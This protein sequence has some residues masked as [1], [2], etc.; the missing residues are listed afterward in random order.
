MRRFKY[1]LIP[2]ITLIAL[3]PLVDSIYS[4]KCEEVLAQKDITDIKHEYNNILR[5]RGGVLKDQMVNDKD[6]LLLGSSELSSDVEQNP[7]N[8]FPFT[9]SEYDVSIF[10]R[11]YSQSLQHSSILNSMNNLN[12]DDKVALI[13]SLQWFQRPDGIKGEEY[14]VNFS[15]YQFYKMINSNVIS[16]ENKLY[17]AKRNYDLLRKSN[18]YLEER[19]YAGL[20]VRD[21]VISRGILTV[22]KPYYKFK[23]YLL[24]IKDKIQ[25]YKTLRNLENKG[26][27]LNINSIKW[28]EEYKKAEEQ[29]TSSATNNPLYVD[30]YYYDT[31]L[32]DKYDELEGVSKDINLMIS[33]EIDD[34]EYFLNVSQDLGVKPLIV[35]MPV[36]GDY[37]DY[38]GLDKNKRTEYYNKIES[39]AEEKGF[40]VLNLQNKEYEKYYL[41]DVMHLGWKG[42][43]NINEEASKYFNER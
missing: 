35:L 16:K 18:E 19:I 31:Y 27:Q 43:L 12:S 15:E 14:S 11:A 33:K 7:I 8:M 5:D 23:E 17:Y 40:E 25:T 30:D 22:L 41:K 37:Y 32:R 24:G 6:L 26:D 38:L 36:H 20:Y 39:M 9:G 28:K 42:W 34:Y 13:V 3:I 1:L 2:L 29:G 21:N 10:G 4:R